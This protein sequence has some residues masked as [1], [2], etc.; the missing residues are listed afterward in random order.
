[1]LNQYLNLTKSGIVIFVLL[2]VLAGYAI[3]FPVGQPLSLDIPLI[4]MLGVYLLSAGSFSLNQAQEWKKDILMPRTQSRPIP[5]KKIYPWQAIVLGFSFI[6][7][8]LLIL[9]MLSPLASFVGFLT[10]LMYN[11][12]YTYYWKPFMAFGA[13][14]GAIPGALPVVIGYSVNTNHIFNPQL[15]YLFILLFI[16]QMPH[17]WAIAL[18]YSDDYKKGGF[19]VLPT[20]IGEKK[21]LFHIALYQMVYLGLALAAPLFVRTDILYLLVI[22]PLTLKLFYEF[23]IFMKSD[24]KKNWLPFFL[25]TTLSIIVYLAVPVI[26]KW[27]FVVIR[28]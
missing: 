17:F 23:Y 14:P 20:V 10:V 7:I 9:Y 11:G 18:K 21:T 26:D 3:S 25:W 16:W 8:G 19:P 27:L 28:G 5:S 2:S 22:I 12:F 13:V 4:L 1:M 15:I 6:T 24:G